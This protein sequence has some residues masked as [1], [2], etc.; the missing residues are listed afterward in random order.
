MAVMAI[1][2]GLDCRNCNDFQKQ[3][4][5][6]LE[7]SPIPQRWRAG[8]YE[9][10]RCPR[11]MTTTQSKEYIN[12]YSLFKINPAPNGQ[13]WINEAKKFIDA[14]NIIALEL[15]EKPNER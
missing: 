10:R 9:S 15:V 3:D 5:G 4:R 11:K 7:D 2:E 8:E 12:A 13:G 6:C 1:T 14:M